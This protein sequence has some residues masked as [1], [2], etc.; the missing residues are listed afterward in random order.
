ML[1][2]FVYDLRAQGLKI[3]LGEVLSLA[4]ALTLGLHDSS[5]DGF[6]DVARALCVHREADL[7]AFDRAFSARFRGVEITSMNLLK[8]LNE[9]LHNPYM[10]RQLTEEER[11][12]LKALDVDELKK[13]LEERLKEQKERHDGGNRW[14]GTGGTSPFGNNGVNPAGIRIGGSGGGRSALAVAGERRFKA[15][16]SDVVLDVRSMELALRK[17]KGLAREGNELE[18]DLEGTIDATA[19]QAGELEIVLR[20]PRKPNVK[21]VL[22]MDVGGSM[23]PHAHLCSRMF[24][25]AKRASNLKIVEPYYFHNALYGKVYRDAGM[26]E[27]V[28]ITDLL[29]Q[30]DRLWKLV[31][32][33]DALMHPSELLG[34]GWDRDLHDRGYG[35]MT[36]IG[37]FMMVAKHFDR[38]AWLNPEP[39]QYW[40]GTAELIS[41]VFPMYELTLDGLG[42]AV[43]HLSRR[44]A[45]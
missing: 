9:W 19:R 36:A 22:L 17:L 38:Q 44:G 35:D 23:D 5:L 41:R 28:R 27:A 11:A 16:R 39:A 40:N 24:S 37:W 33:G 21:V 13:L 12:A 43:T 14:I 7:D 29:T 34:G 32:V 1:V 20:P 10:R 4:R 42:A 3:G 6:Y 25:A 8:E 2:E 45:V 26:R 18:L 31:V 30:T 15:Y